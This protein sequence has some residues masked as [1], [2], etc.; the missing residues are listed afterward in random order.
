[1]KMSGVLF[2][3]ITM[4]ECSVSIAFATEAILGFELVNS[5]FEILYLLQPEVNQLARVFVQ[6]NNNYEG[7]QLFRS[8]ETNH[9]C[10]CVFVM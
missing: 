10:W 2:Q 9:D 3:C 6:H 5:S 1:M 8:H 4:L 7:L